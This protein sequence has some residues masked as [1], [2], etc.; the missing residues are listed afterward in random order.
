MTDQA[1]ELRNLIRAG[2][3]PGHGGQS[4]AQV[5][6]FSG[7][8]SGVGTTTLAT[9]MAVAFAQ[10][11]HRVVLVDAD[12]LNGGV[13]RLCG[14]ASPSV[15]TEAVGDETSPKALLREGPA[16]IQVLA[17]V[18]SMRPLNELSGSVESRFVA[19]LRQLDG[20][21]D[22][23]VVDSGNGVRSLT[24]SLWKLADHVLLITSPD[25]VALI[26]SY[27][28]IKALRDCRAAT[29]VSAVV[30]QSSSVMA[31]DA[32][33]RLQAACDRFLGETLVYGGNVPLD[34]MLAVAAQMQMPMVMQAPTASATRAIRAV[35][36]KLCHEPCDSRFNVA[37]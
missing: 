29:R 2:E 8:K 22:Y 30:N 23:V 5:L 15:I 32:Y 10:D 4:A 33:T 9:N 24:R 35:I 37:G 25:A 1:T 19:K 7:G 28:A 13:C 34:T 14:I 21:F 17:G 26:D 20:Q 18:S 12:L 16:G 6:V 36:D 11:G 27:L 31:A 3:Q